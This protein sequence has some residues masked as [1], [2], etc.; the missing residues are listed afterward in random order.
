MYKVNSF[1]DRRFG[2]RDHR[3]L[4]EKN[5]EEEYAIRKKIKRLQKRKIAL[6]NLDSD[7]EN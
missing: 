5:Q 4:N 6:F 2:V 7:D 1:K 3:T